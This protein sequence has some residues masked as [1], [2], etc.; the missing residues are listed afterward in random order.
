M[1]LGFPVV[2]DEGMESRIYGHFA[3]A[4]MFLS[5]DTESGETKAFEN[6]DQENPQEGCNPFKA[7]VSSRIDNMIV[8]GVGDGF[9]ELLNLLG[10]R[11]YQAESENIRENVELFAKDALAPLEYQNSAAEGRC[12]SVDE[13]GC[14][15]DHGDYAEHCH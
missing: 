1:R 11:V 8:D 9:I 7:L 6:I 5:V 13:H 14:N 2:S 15:H 3:S 4:P 10:M 12:D